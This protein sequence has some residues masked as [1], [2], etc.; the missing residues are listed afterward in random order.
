ML[1]I[2]S[3]SISLSVVRPDDGPRCAEERTRASFKTP[4]FFRCRPSSPS[5]LHSLSFASRSSSVSS[6]SVSLQVVPSSSLLPAMLLPLA[7]V[8]GLVASNALAKPSLKVSLSAPSSVD[9]V[10]D[11]KLKAAVTNTG[12]K[13]L[14]VLKL[15][16]VLDTSQTA[17]FK[18]TK[19]STRAPF[20]G[21]KVRHLY[22]C[23]LRATADV[24]ASVM[25]DLS[26]LQEADRQTL[27]HDPRRQ[28][29]H[30]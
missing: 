20:R 17:S 24:A 12:T 6:S 30:R 26:R 13:D 21:P 18:V 4:L 8:L 28:D 25:S 9:S 16:S 27:G 1:F 23:I 29:R 10:D 5:S 7:G 14:H 19:G 22:S 3:H 15:G 2:A 11:L